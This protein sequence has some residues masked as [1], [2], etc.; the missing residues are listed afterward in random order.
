MPV[1]LVLG[2]EELTGVPL[3]ILKT[4]SNDMSRETPSDLWQNCM[5]FAT[6]HCTDSVKRKKLEEKGSREVLSVGYHCGNKVL[7]N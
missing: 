4:A 1:C 5:A 3:N 2:R 7:T 6:S